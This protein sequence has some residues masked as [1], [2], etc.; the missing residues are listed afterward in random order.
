MRGELA[1][2]IDN[3]LAEVECFKRPKHELTSGAPTAGAP[4]F[5]CAKPMATTFLYRCH[6]PSRAGLGR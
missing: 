5:L 1:S 6:Q 2:A 4:F 3:G